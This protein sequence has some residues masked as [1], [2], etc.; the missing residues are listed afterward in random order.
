MSQSGFC[1]HEF[2]MTDLRGL[3]LFACFLFR[4]KPRPDIQYDCSVGIEER[5][6][7]FLIARRQMIRPLCHR[8]FLHDFVCDDFP[9]LAAHNFVLAYRQ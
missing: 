4:A 3:R 2:M 6:R 5:T 8:Q 1:H 9:V 7:T